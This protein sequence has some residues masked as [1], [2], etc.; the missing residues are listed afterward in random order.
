MRTRSATSREGIPMAEQQQQPP[1]QQQQP[2]QQQQQP[3]QQQQQP[4]RHMMIVPHEVEVPMFHG[5]DP[6]CASLRDFQHALED[7]WQQRPD[8]T[9]ANRSNRAWH[10]LTA[11][12]RRELETQGLDHQSP[13]E[14]LLRALKDTY[15]DQRSVSQRAGDFYG[16][17]QEGFE[18]LRS[19]SQRL[20]EAFRSL[21][22]A[23]VKARRATVDGN[24]LIERFLEG[25]RD[26]LL[27]NLTRS[28]QLAH[29]RAT[30]QEI[31][32]EAMEMEEAG[33]DPP[34]VQQHAAS[35]P[36]DDTVAQIK[37][38]REEIATLRQK[39][40]DISS[41]G[42]PRREHYRERSPPVCFLCNGRGHFARACPKSGNGLR[43]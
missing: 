19:Y 43:R 17:K 4:P 21:V 14:D 39:V 37:L 26:S 27:K 15:G 24:M 23:Q 18:G 36:A 8:F 22:S 11:P 29:P 33:V 2:P 40:E 5:R 20:H 38:L 7:L 6:R 42:P 13:V 34:V 16:C 41:R 12:V 3:P 25:M 28:Y 10:K 30:F 35:R 1:Q 31:R 9:P 32:T